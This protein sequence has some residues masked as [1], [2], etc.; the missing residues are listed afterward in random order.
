MP[1]ALVVLIE[2]GRY[3]GRLEQYPA[4]LQRMDP[5]SFSLPP[6]GCVHRSRL[7]TRGMHATAVMIGEHGVSLLR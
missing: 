2:A 3:Y 1:R 4:L 6:G 5:Y 7:M